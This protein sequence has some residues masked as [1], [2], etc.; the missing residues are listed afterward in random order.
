[1]APFIIWRRQSLDDVPEKP[2]PACP[3][4]QRHIV[5]AMALAETI[6]PKRACICRISPGESNLLDHPGLPAQPGHRRRIEIRVSSFGTA[7]V[8]SDSLVC[9]L[10]LS[11]R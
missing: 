6:L 7:Y 2:G 8:S 9:Q 5:G 1:M 4:S 3:T 11:T 10:G